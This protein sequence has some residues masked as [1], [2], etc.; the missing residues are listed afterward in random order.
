[1][2]LWAWQVLQRVTGARNRCIP[3]DQIAFSLDQFT[4][5]LITS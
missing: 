1:M 4:I 5:L 3:V 2:T